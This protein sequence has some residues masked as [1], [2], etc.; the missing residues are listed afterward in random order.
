[1]GR[2]DALKPRRHKGALSIAAR[3]LK[4]HG[5]PREVVHDREADPAGF[6]V[7]EKKAAG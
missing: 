3:Y 4:A 2:A 5:D 1:M 6:L 7:R